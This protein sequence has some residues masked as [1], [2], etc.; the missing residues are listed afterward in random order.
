MGKKSRQRQRQKQQQQQLPPPPQTLWEDPASLF[1][2]CSWCGNVDHRWRSCP[3]GP[4]ADWCGRCELDGHSWAG[5]P[6]NPDQEQLQ[7]PSSAA[8]PPLPTSPP[9][10]PSQEIWD[11]LMHPEADLFHD[12]P[13][14]INT[15]WRRDGGRWER[16]EAQHHPA[17]FAELALMVVNY[18]A[19]DMGEAPVKVELSSREPEGELLLSR[20]PERGEPSSRE[21]ER[22]ELSSREP[23]R[24]ELLSREPERGFLIKSEAGR[25][26]AYTFHS[27]ERT[28]SR[29]K[30]TEKITLGSQGNSAFQP[31]TASC[32]IV[33]QGQTPNPA[34]S[35]GKSF[36]PI[37]MSYKIVSGSPISTPSHSPLPHTSTSTPVHVKHSSS[38]INKPYMIVDKP[39]QMIGSPTGKQTSISQAFQGAK[40]PAPKIHGSSFISS[41]VK[42]ESLFAVMPPLCPFGTQGKVQSPKSV[43]G[44]LGTFTKQEPGEAPQQQQHQMMVSMATSQQT[45]QQFVTVKGGH[46]IALSPQKQASAVGTRSKQSKVVEISM[47]FT[48]QSAIKQAV[49]IS[50]GQI[51][52]AKPSTAANKVI[53]QKQMITQGVAKAIVS[54][55]SATVMAQSVHTVTKAQISSS[56]APKTGVQGSVMATLQLPANN[57]AN[58]ANLPPGTKLYLTTNSKNP[59]GKGKLLLIPQGAI[60]RS[61][62]PSGQQNACSAGG[63][64][65]T[66]SSSLP[67]NLSYTSYILKQ[68]P[69]GT[70]LVGQPA[71][72]GS[73]K[74]VKAGSASHSVP[75]SSGQQRT[76]RVTAGQKAAILAQV[77]GQTSTVKLSDGSVK[78]VASAPHLSKPGTTT[79]RMTGEVITAASSI[80]ATAAASSAAGAAPQI[81]I[82]FQPVELERKVYGPAENMIFKA[83][84]Q[85]ATEILR[86]ALAV[87]FLRSPQNRSAAAA[88]GSAER[89]GAGQAEGVRGAQVEELAETPV[90][91]PRVKKRI[92]AEEQSTVADPPTESTVQEPP[93]DPEGSFTAVI[94]K[95]KMQKRSEAVV[96]GESIWGPVAAHKG[97][98]EPQLAAPGEPSHGS[99]VGGD[100]GSQP[101]AAAVGESGPGESGGDGSDQAVAA[102]LPRTGKEANG[103]AGLASS[104]A[105]AL[106]S[107][108]SSRPEEDECV[109]KK[110]RDLSVTTDTLSDIFTSCTIF[111]L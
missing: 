42:E 13:I 20:E 107:A 76:I 11:W 79:L 55:A 16:W 25:S 6:H 29:P 91:A 51:L 84:E 35:P 30:P 1:S 66:T 34:E 12:L 7:T 104:D 92:A 100:A 45:A 5:C 101:S 33:S 88:E 73:G 108:E 23:E 111:I 27:S 15:L 38:V 39:G 102:E 14:A 85:F 96:V 37:T 80:R 69:Q 50:G 74:Q 63:G 105:M 53:G 24:E 58:L 103:S 78:T 99:L 54:A 59:S 97:S 44:G 9:S 36:Q 70:F 18:L 46:M 81:G 98:G 40:S 93:A 67:P 10:P 4:P 31:I 41:A 8:T 48:L 57:L 75:S 52:V 65:Q 71:P 86:E 49:P 83:T 3:D 87:A 82:S 106:P 109:H 72:Q 22:G 28:P 95:K 90:P 94:K 60:L 47:G 62:N 43:S 64:S 89:Q 2:W 56:G 61:S 26:T 17:S 110:F 32:K 77:A 68:T 21:P 19:V